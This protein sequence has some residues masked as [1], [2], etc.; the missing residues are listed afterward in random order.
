MFPISLFLYKVRYGRARLMGNK[1]PPLFNC[2]NLLDDFS[3]KFRLS[4]IVT[5]NPSEPCCGTAIIVFNIAHV[6][7]PVPHCM[8]TKRNYI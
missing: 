1:S 8:I 3:L 6:K 7:I 2:L 4:I 5:S